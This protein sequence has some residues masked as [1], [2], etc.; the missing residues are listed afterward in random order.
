MPTP[1]LMPALS[2]TME[3]G[4]L[5]KWHVKVGDQ[6]KSGDVIAEIETD[7]ATMEV[8]AVDEGKVG[9]IVVPEGTENVKVNAPIA[10]LLGEGETVADAKATAKLAPPKPSEI[11][12]SGGEKPAA[13]VARATSP[14]PQLSPRQRGEGANVVTLAPAGGE[15]RARPAL[16]AGVRG[17][18]VQSSE[19]GRVFASPLARRMASQQGIDIAAVAGSGPHGRIVKRDIE[20]ARPAAMRAP[21]AAPVAARAEAPAH[22]LRRLAGPPDRI[23]LRP[24]PQVMVC[25]CGHQPGDQARLLFPR[26]SWRNKIR[27]GDHFRK[28][29]PRRAPT[30][31]PGPVESAYA[32]RCAQPRR[33]AP[34]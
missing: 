29:S 2:P 30:L 3:E 4:T 28:G 12:P 1:I 34:N 16:E 5:T 27:P 11:L 7:K 18:A 21:A 14:A 10:I 19:G 25:A 20:T 15:G 13:P 31:S 22:T 9:E 8:E 33:P 6:V 23:Q 24:E 32:L 26:P 17:T